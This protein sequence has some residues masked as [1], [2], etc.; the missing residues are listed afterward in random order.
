M[1][2]EKLQ[3]A[4][5]VGVFLKSQK[6]DG[7]ARLD[8]LIPKLLALVKGVKDLNILLI[9]G[10]DLT[11][12]GTPFEREINPTY[13]QAAA[14]SRTARRPVVTT[15]VA[16]QGQ[17]VSWSVVLAGAPIQ[18]PK[19]APHVQKQLAQKSPIPKNQQPSALASNEVVT[20]NATLIGQAP[21]AEHLPAQPA[22]NVLSSRL[23]PEVNS[24]SKLAPGP[25]NSASASAGPG[26][27]V[28]SENVEPA[29]VA[30][31]RAVGSVQS[32]VITSKGALTNRESIPENSVQP[33]TAL[34]TPLPSPDTKAG[35]SQNGQPLTPVNVNAALIGTD[36][37]KPAA[38]A[39]A[40]NSADEKL[41][42]PTSPAPRNPRDQDKSLASV[43]E[44]AGPEK[45]SEKPTSTPW[46]ALRPAPVPVAAREKPFA[47]NTNLV[48]QSPTLPRP[49]LAITTAPEPFLTARILFLIGSA[50][51]VT[52][53]V[54]S[55]LLARFLRHAPEPSFISRSIDRHQP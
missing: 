15:L 31:K 41:T 26:A 53:L 48:E 24:T 8:A 47:A 54:L 2:D 1:P 39:P 12:K 17:I 46:T 42:P 5:R 34:T 51:A 33:P 14:Q 32:I 4:S 44:T 21:V 50:L 25:L 3:V 19:R 7:H 18:L 45:P 23:P 36:N 35:T 16:R 20:A 13:L 52:A 9:S 40:A 49:A 30:T 38:S 11:W 27:V 43:R 6:Y 29:P 37:P 10:P 55:F 22:T 28:N